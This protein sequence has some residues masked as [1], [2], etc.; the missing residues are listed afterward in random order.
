MHDTTRDATEVARR[1]EQLGTEIASVER[2]LL[3]LRRERAELLTRF[4]AE[5]FPGCV[6][7]FEG[8]PVTVVGRECPGSRMVAVLDAAD[9]KGRVP[10]SQLEPWTLQDEIAFNRARRRAELLRSVR[11][12][13]STNDVDD[14]LLAAL[15]KVLE[16]KSNPAAK[17][18]SEV[19]VESVRSGG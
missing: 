7:K 17:S 6:V 18:E 14:D 2:R 5:L 19:P 1:C 11:E 9:R 3:L 12:T 10:I 13:L 15:E 4:R 16:F 8:A